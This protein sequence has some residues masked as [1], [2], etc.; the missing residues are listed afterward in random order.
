MATCIPTSAKSVPEARLDWIGT[1]FERI[2]A[3]HGEHL[4]F[5]AMENLAYGGSGKMDILS[6]V[7]WEL[8]RRIYR[9]RPELE[10][11]SVY[12]SS[13]KKA[14]AG[15][16]KAKKPA[17]KEAIETKY[18]CTFDSEDCYDAYGLLRFEWE[19]WKHESNRK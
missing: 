4:H 6:G 17:I 2:L 3:L 13:W 11:R 10:I 14:I 8:R 19:K 18:G 16:G 5:V 1:C 15:H 12:I 7:Y 9:Y